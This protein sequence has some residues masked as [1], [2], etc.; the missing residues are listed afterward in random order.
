MNVRRLILL[1]ASL[2]VATAAAGLILFF[3]WQKSQPSFR[4]GLDLVAAAQAYSRDLEERGQPLPASVSLEDLIEAGYLTSHDARAFD[5]IEVQ[6]SLEPAV[7]NETYP[8]SI[9]IQA[10][11]PDGTRVVLR[12]DGS[13]HALPK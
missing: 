11:M 9:L 10:R 6:V 5:G 4:G 3:S 8:Q 13:V 1:T 2:A 12:A 7:T